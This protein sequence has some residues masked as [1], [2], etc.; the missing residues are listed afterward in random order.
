MIGSK[1]ERDYACIPT[2]NQSLFDSFEV[3][4][5]LLNIPFFLKLRLAWRLYSVKRVFS[6]KIRF[7]SPCC[8]KTK[9]AAKHECD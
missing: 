4:I 3:Y 6:N 2:E 9:Q 8:T 5:Y 1:G 7:K